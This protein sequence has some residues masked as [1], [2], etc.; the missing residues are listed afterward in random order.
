MLGVLTGFAIIAAIIAVGYVVG[1]IG[2]L[3]P[4]AR[5][6]LARLVFFVLAPSL[7]FTILADAEVG[8]L[9]SPL[10]VVSLL[11]AAT[12]FAVYGLVARLLW[13][14]GVAETV[15]GAL[16]AGY[17]NGNN[18]GI[19]VAVYVLGDPA[20]VAPV[21]LVQLLLFAPL[22][23]AVLD[24]AQQ[25]RVSVG[26]LATGP[27]RNPIIIGSALGLLVAL[28]DVT[29]PEAFMEPFRIIGGAAV[30]LMLLSYGISLHGQKVLEQ[31]QTAGMPCSPR[32]SSS[33]SCLPS[34]GPQ[35][36]CSS[37]STTRSSS[38]SWPSPRSPQRRTCSTTPSGTGAARPSRATRSS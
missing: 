11:A 2:L 35:G 38:W 8:Q 22:G 18:I 28:L 31:G 33:S 14:R 26:R 37:T 34:P 29:P 6:I 1:R 9:F 4:D 3:G 20:Y 25:G 13:H 19:P 32:R 10:L 15:I 5:P 36:C 17:V 27:L 12:S 30:P 16:S 7:L 23:L 21:I 24:A